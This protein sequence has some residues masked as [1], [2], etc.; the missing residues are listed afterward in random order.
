V[1][2]G[3]RSRMHLKSN[4]PEVAALPLGVRLVVERMISEKTSAI[5]ALQNEVNELR[6]R[7]DAMEKRREE[8]TS[9]V[10]DDDSV[11]GPREIE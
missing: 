4:S 11:G 10:D 1:R 2:K 6:D 9:S 7:V 8:A 5:E 3:I